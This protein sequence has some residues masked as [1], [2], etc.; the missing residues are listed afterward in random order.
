MPRV[1]RDLL[2]VCS[3]YVAC[4]VRRDTPAPGT[5]LNLASGQTRRIGEV[6]AELTELAGAATEIELNTSRLRDTKIRM[7][8]CNVRRQRRGRV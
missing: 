2:D 4:I 5:V 7:A 1:L 3:A 8:C 6:L